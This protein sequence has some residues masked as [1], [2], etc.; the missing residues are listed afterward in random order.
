MDFNGNL[1]TRCGKT[2]P[3]AF[4]SWIAGIILFPGYLPAFTSSISESVSFGHHAS[5]TMGGQ[6]PIEKHYRSFL[7]EASHIKI[8]YKDEQYYEKVID[9]V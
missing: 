1:L 6:I 2:Y 9:Q 5:M 4:L 7:H 3:R 8:D